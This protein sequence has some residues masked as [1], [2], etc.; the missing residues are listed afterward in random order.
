MDHESPP[1]LVQ[2]EEEN[3]KQCLYYARTRLG[4]VA[5]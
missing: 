1:G 5:E 3:I 4:F 2:L